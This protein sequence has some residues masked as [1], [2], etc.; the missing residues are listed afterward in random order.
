ML[1]LLSLIFDI[2]GQ[3]YNMP[4][5]ARFG[6]ISSPQGLSQSS[7][8]SLAQDNK[9]F[10][11]IGTRDG[12]NRYDGYNFKT[13]R[14]DPQD[15]NSISNNE[16]TVIYCDKNGDIWLGTRGGGLNKFI[17]RSSRFIR[18]NK[19]VQE[20]IIRDLY[21]TP[22]G[23]LWIGSSDG[24][25]KT[26]N[27]LGNENVKFENVTRKAVFYEENNKLISL[28][29]KIISVVSIAHFSNDTMLI[30]TES[31]LFFYLP[32]VN[33]FIR[34]NCAEINA[35]IVT[36][37]Q[38]TKKRDLWI[39]SFN[40]LLKVEFYPENTARYKTITYNIHQNGSRKIFSNRI[41]SLTEDSNG[42]IWVGTRGGG[43][44]KIDHD[45]NTTY[46]LNDKNDV[47]S[48]RDNIVNSLLIDN[49]EVLWIGT[50]SQGCNLLDLNCKK[51]VHIRN[52]PNNSNSLSDALV[53][54]ISGSS[55][56]T[57]WVGSAVKGLD[58]LIFSN[59]GVYTIKHLRVIPVIPGLVTSEIISLMLDKEQEL[60]IGNATDY[61]VR[62][63]EHKGFNSYLVNGYVFS[64]LEDSEGRIWYGTWGQ[65]LGWIDKKSNKIHRI[66]E[67]Q[68][69]I[70]TISSDKIIAL[71]EDR[72]KNLWIGTK[73]GGVNILPL[74]MVESASYDFISYRYDYKDPKSLSHNDVY[75]IK[76]DKQGNIWLG[77]GSGL[78]KIEWNR[79][80]SLTDALMKGEVEFSVYLEKDGLSNGVVFGIL[81][82]RQ[83]NLW[84]STN[85]G[86]SMFDQHSGKFI[87][88]NVNDGLQAN[89]FYH[90]AYFQDSSN[91]MYFG[92]VNGLTVF[93]ADSI[94]QTPVNVNIIITGLKIFNNIIHP[95]EKINNRII[96]ENDIFYTN[97]I[98]LTYKEKEFTLEF[99]ALQFA[100]PQRIQ[101]EYRLKGFNDNWQKA[102]ANSRTATY[103]NLDDGDYVFEVRAVTK[104]GFYVSQP[105]EL[106][107]TIIPPFWKTPWFSII[108]I[109]III[110][111]LFLFRS[112]SLIA[113]KEKNKLLI[114][115]L[116]HKRLVEMTEAKMRFLT[117]ISHEIRT[118][119]TLIN[120]P[121]ETVLNEGIMDENSK[122]NLKLIS[123]NVQRLLQLINQLLQLRKI[124]LGLLKPDFK[125]VDLIPFIKD[126]LMRFEQHASRRNINLTFDYFNDHI[127]LQF[128]PELMTTVLYNLLANAFKYTDDEG[129]IFV[130]IYKYEGHQQQKFYH[131]IRKKLKINRKEPQ[132][133]AIEIS[134]TGKG[135]PEHE[136]SNIFKRFYQ[137]QIPGTYH[138][139]GSGIGLS[140]VKEYVELHNG[141]I[142]VKSEI[143]KGSTFIVYLPAESIILSGKT[144]QQEVKQT[145]D[146]GIS[147]VQIDSLIIDDETN[148][149]KINEKQSEVK[150]F[151]PPILIIED[152][153]EL[154]DY[155]VNY[156]SKTYR[157]SVAYNGDKGFKKAK[158]EMPELI[159]SDVMLP[160]MNGLQ[161]CEVLKTS[162]ETSHIPIILITARADEENIQEGYQH[163]ADLYITKPFNVKLLDTQVKMLIDSRK[164]LRERYSRQVLLKPADVAITPVDEKFLQQLIQIIEKHIADSEFDVT[165]LVN[166][167]NMSHSTILRKVKALTGISLVEFI[168]NHRLK[169]AALIL[170]KEKLPVSEVSYM[171]GFTDPKYFTKCFVRQFGLT[172]SE[173]IAEHHPNNIEKNHK[174]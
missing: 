46:F 115:R 27:Y 132:W 68:N 39:G 5:D 99:S 65:G 167:M 97:K 16:I 49:T 168:K 140:L 35:A 171:V 9:G 58:Q 119:L 108:Y 41:E 24:L 50:E 161:L 169:K 114:E 159:I 109:A 107:I 162:I 86:L 105:A 55:E 52:I 93:N 131:N 4:S 7:V 144:R 152:D 89:E 66:Q 48:I 33:K 174:L 63:S 26:S 91:N 64:L 142:D 156:F 40:G 47:A 130:R 102:D 149:T 42:N 62:Y 163:G 57:V 30:G 117:N 67:S 61:L 166:G 17:V 118:P 82:D 80:Q 11:W 110:G 148:D 53:T 164:R 36:S 90:N 135:M 34:F 96:L 20:N 151:G 139:T 128:D 165:R 122:K 2:N 141:Y 153:H 44:V 59:Y 14:F 145:E 71:Y 77:T 173:Y 37:I 28:Q 81:E 84:L 94:K 104:D 72:L 95:G 112:Y 70:R 43:L 83:G 88:Y 54:A 31:G 38:V 121:L 124:D 146:I 76:Q 111:A 6:V 92:G 116:E 85:N 101:Y 56:K 155:L 79:K 147:K 75:C 74:H 160:E 120:D 78:N 69:A 25:L 143:N 12:L 29:K 15:T 134:D 157:V 98:V 73:G 60:W 100:N 22:D 19:L 51:F 18:F 45:G 138:S 8:F 154:A 21:E 172:P 113:V 32:S 103:T 170:Q 133:L 137:V 13:Y 1:V 3:Q 129:S 158:E 126:I 106:H 10:I 87:N 23:T 125:E 127:I 136:I 150:S 123:K